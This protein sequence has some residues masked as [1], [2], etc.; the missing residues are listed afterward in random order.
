MDNLKQLK[1]D[2][3]TLLKDV[4]PKSTMIEWREHLV[5]YFSHKKK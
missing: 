1:E 5:E 2:G 4:F 3:Y